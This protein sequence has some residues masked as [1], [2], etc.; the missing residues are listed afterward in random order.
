[1]SSSVV[2][3]AGF[4]FITQ[5]LARIITK[6][7]VDSVDISMAS[8]AGVFYVSPFAITLR[9]FTVVTMNGSLAV[10]SFFAFFISFVF[11]FNSVRLTL[12]T[13]Q[14]SYP[15]SVMVKLFVLGC[16]FISNGQRNLLLSVGFFLSF[17]WKSF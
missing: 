13:R 5:S 14:H 1:M 6:L 2:Y 11:F 8:S 16:Q 10:A 17:A 4:I 12:A 9:N 7:F 15:V 3:A